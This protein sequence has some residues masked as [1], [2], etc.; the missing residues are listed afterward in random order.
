MHE[1]LKSQMHE[2]IARTQMMSDV[3]GRQWRNVNKR[4]YN[5]T[6][7]DHTDTSRHFISYLIISVLKAVRFG[8]AS[9]ASASALPL[10]IAVILLVAILPTKLEAP[11]RFQN[12]KPK[13]L[14]WAY[15]VKIRG[16]KQNVMG[17]R[18]PFSDFI[19][20]STHRVAV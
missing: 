1:P 19:L 18:K 6:S 8:A 16:I 11:Y 5:V 13:S 17:Y 7:K 4:T 3:F 20:W 10:P 14:S 2:Q 12:P 9:T 15:A